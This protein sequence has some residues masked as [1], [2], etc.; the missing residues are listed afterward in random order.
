VVSG[1]LTHMAVGAA[2]GAVLVRLAPELVPGDPAVL[3]MAVPAAS[4]L[5]AT[6]PD[7]DH[8]EAWASRRV[9]WVTGGAGAVVT[10]L[11]VLPTL[12]PQP[13]ASVAALLV[14]GALLGVGIGGLILDA[15]RLIASGHRGGT[16]GLIAPAALLLVAV[17]MGGPW[18]ALPLL[19]AWGWLL[20]VLADV[21][22]PGGWRPLAPFP[23]PVLRLPRGLAKHGETLIGCAALTVLAAVLGLPAWLAPAAGVTTALVLR[24]RRRARGWR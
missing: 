5:A 23:G 18:A 8:P 11:G 13:P 7:L 16:H 10:V 1:Y 19:L 20:H 3:A 14:M 9:W 4:A 22:T 12:D 6:W 21:V 24:T 2:G 17:L 15:L